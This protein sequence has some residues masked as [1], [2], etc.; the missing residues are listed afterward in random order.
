MVVKRVPNSGGKQNEEI[1]PFYCYLFGQFTAGLYADVKTVTVRVGIYIFESTEVVNFTAPYGV[2]AVARRLDLS[3][4]VF[5]IADTMRTIAEQAG[6]TV[7]PKY[8]LKDKPYMSAF[9]I[10]GGIVTHTEVFN[11]S[12][13]DFVKSLPKDTLVTLVCTG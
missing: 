3:I 13:I 1:M 11:H 5:L 12:L 9:I 4:E 7:L 8:S 10:P 2:F 6:L